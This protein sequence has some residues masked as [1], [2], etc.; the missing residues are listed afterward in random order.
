MLTTSF[1]SKQR[2]GRHVQSNVC[3]GVVFANF[4]NDDLVFDDTFSVDHFCKSSFAALHSALEFS[5][6]V[7]TVLLQRG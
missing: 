5:C 2:E 4:L 1:P 6:C 7:V 3:V